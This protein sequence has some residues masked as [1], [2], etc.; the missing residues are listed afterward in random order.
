MWSHRRLRYKIPYRRILL[1]SLWHT[2]SNESRRHNLPHGFPI[3]Y[4]S[5][6]SPLHGCGIQSVNL[7][8][9]PVQSGGGTIFS[10]FPA[11]ALSS[12]NQDRSLRWQQLFR[13]GK[14]VPAI[15]YRFLWGARCPKDAPRPPHRQTHNCVPVPSPLCCFSCQRPRTQYCQFHFLPMIQEGFRGLRQML[16]RRNDYV[17]QI[18]YYS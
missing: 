8:F 3:S 5:Y 4:P 18:S 6:L 9:L 10:E 14:P 12:D 11:P 7:L 2:N 16:C 13:H 17:Y 1:P 15:P